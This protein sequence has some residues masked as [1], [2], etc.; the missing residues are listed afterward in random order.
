MAQAKAA[1][2]AQA[3]EGERLLEIAVVNIAA[4]F[5]PPLSAE[6]H[7]PPPATGAGIAEWHQPGF[8]SARSWRTEGGRR[9]QYDESRPPAG[10]RGMAR[11]C[12]TAGGDGKCNARQALSAP[13]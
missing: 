8:A 9:R 11:R 5:R 13:G 3:S 2:P 10:A 4:A 7:I 6:A 12:T 1:Y